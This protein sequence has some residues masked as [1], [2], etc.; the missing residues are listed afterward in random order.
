M[1]ESDF[2]PYLNIYVVWHPDF[3]NG[4][5]IAEQIYSCFNHDINAPLSRGIGIPVYFRSVNASKDVETPLTIKL[6]DAHRSVVIVLINSG[7][8]IKKDWKQYVRDL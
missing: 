4:Q 8:A 2:K 7:L 6:D 3:D 5:N 1:K